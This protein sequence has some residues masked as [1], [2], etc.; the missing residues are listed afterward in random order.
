[1]SVTGRSKLDPEEQVEV[2]VGHGEVA[3]DGSGVAPA[4]RG[5]HEAARV[6][7]EDRRQPVDRP[8]LV[9]YPAGPGLHA[10]RTAV[11]SAD[12]AYADL[13]GLFVG[14]DRGGGRP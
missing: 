11:V 4:E 7:L 6:E 8:L 3:A 12:H 5:Q 14:R 2:A 13:A 10:P 1:M 9:R